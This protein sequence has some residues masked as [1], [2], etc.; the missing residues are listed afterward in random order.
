V[1]ILASTAKAGL[2][3]PRP[4]KCFANSTNGFAPPSERRAGPLTSALAWPV[5]FVLPN[6]SIASF[7]QQ[8]ALCIPSKLREKAI[9]Q[10]RSW[11]ERSA[12]FH[13]KNR[14]N[15]SNDFPQLCR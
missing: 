6:P 10:L 11:L 4:R 12:T 7:R 8:M 3:R 14:F 15:G 5:T 2:T 1:G 13:T 9:W